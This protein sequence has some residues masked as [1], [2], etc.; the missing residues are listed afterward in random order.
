MTDWNSPRD[1]QESRR[2][3]FVEV[4]ALLIATMTLAPASSGQ[5][6]PVVGSGDTGKTP[7][8]FFTEMM[9]VRVVN[10]DVFV[11]DRSGLPIAGLQKEDFELRVDGEVVPISNFY[12]ATRSLSSPERPSERQDDSSF[13]PLETIPEDTIR[14]AHVVILVDHTRLRSNNRNRAFAA[15]REAVTRLGPDDLIA[16][17]GIEGSLVFYS[18]FLYDRE[19]VGRILD[20]VSRVG[21]PSRINEA[22]RRQIFGELARGMSGG[23]LGRSSLANDQEIQIRIQAYAAEEYARSVSSLRAI[24]QVLLTLNGVSGRKAVLYVGEGI[25]NRPG[26]G[27]YVEWRNRF[28]GGSDAEIG[29][30]RTDFNTDYTRAIGRYELA[31]QINKLAASA[32]SAGVTL[33]ALDAEA[34]HGN[35]IRSAL[36]EQGATS[37]TLSVV[38][39]NFREPLEAVSKAT[40]GRLLRSSGVLVDQLVNLLGDFDSY[41][42]LG[43]TA[44]AAWEAGSVHKIRVDVAGKGFRVRHREAVRLPEADE[45]EA[46][47]TVAALRYQTANNPLA[48]RA[49]PGLGVERA[50][51]MQAVP[52]KIE[53][54]VGR[55]ELIPRQGVHA[56]SV[57]IYVST[58][59]ADGN[60]SQVQKI[61]FN[62]NIPDEVIDQAREDSAHYDLPLVLR[63]GDQQVAIGVRDNISGRFSAIRVDVARLA[64]SDSS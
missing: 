2:G 29:L 27:M 53:I 12:S 54:P 30:R 39:E 57:T 22:E 5:V 26:E 55:L 45:R 48:I 49:T 13:R 18:D 1:G 56:A 51:G 52:L 43:F 40:G 61:P 10:V 60:A 58:K 35:D 14:R 47:A 63:P 64:P 16:V 21:I 11:N 59:R 9:D 46:G 41:Y 23:I 62:L 34:N 3:G 24:E 50:D 17:V 8:G 6:A 38:D 31:P 19:A 28:G 37:E 42:S 36:T 32:N 44:P 15:V 7:T 20:E 33:Y 25:P 4:V